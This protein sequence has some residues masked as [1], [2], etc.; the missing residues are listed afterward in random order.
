MIKIYGIAKHL[1]PKI[2]LI[3]EV[4]AQSMNEALAFPLEKRSHRFFP[5][6]ARHFISPPDRSEAYTVLEIHLM[7]GRSAAA[8]NRLIHRLFEQFEEQ[9]GVKPVDLEIILQDSP[10]E[11][12]GFRGMTGA[13]ARLDYQIKV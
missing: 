6:D 13:E 3:S 12:W 7:S 2:A 10:P 11:N 8:K 5:M 4:I 9:L 1:E